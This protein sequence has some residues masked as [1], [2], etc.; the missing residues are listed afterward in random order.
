MFLI[1]VEA[2]PR[3]FSYSHIR[4]VKSPGD[5]VCEFIIHS[6]QIKWCHLSRQSWYQ[7][8]SGLCVGLGPSCVELHYG[9]LV[10]THS[11]ILVIQAIWLVKQRRLLSAHARTIPRVLGFSYFSQNKQIW[12]AEIDNL[13]FE[14]GL[15]FN[16]SSVSQVK[17]I[18][19]KTNSTWRQRSM[20][21]VLYGIFS[22]D[23]ALL[24]DT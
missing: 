19:I 8:I 21:Q 12:A 11:V 22:V 9:T 14:V 2:Y 16:R 20:F 4:W 18:N 24:V 1:K 5:E 7:T 6:M 13:N 3:R 10:Y 17:G 23:K 15:S